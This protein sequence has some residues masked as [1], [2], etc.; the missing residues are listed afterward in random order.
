MI[1]KQLVKNFLSLFLSNV[2]GQLFSLWAFVKIASVFGPEGFGRFS[3]AQ[4]VALYFLFLADFGLQTLGTRTIAQEKGDISVHVWNITI[5]RFFLAMCCF[6]LLVIFSFL[7]PKPNEVRLLIII[8]GVALF[9]Y[10]LLLEWVFQGIEQMEYV[11]LGRVLKGVV[12]AGLVFFFINSPDNMVYAA[13]FYVVGFVFASGTLIGIYFRKHGMLISK[14]RYLNLK[15]ILISAIPLAAGSLIAQINYNFGTLALGFYQSDKV[16]GLFSAA[17]KI[18]L[19]L[20][21]FAAVAASNAILPQL[22]RSYKESIGQFNNSLKKLFRVFILFAIPLGIGGSILASR[23]MGFLYTPEYQEAV[24]VF[25]L[26]IWMVVFVISRIVFENALI[27]SRSQRSYLIGFIGAG[28]F[29]ILGN[30]ILVPVLGLV[31]PSVVGILSESALV[32]YFV[33]SCK[34]IRSSEFVILIFKP[35]LAGLLMGLFL[36]FLPLSL[37][38]SLFI[39]IIIYFISLIILHYFTIDELNAYIHLLRQ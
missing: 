19:F 31:A 5:L 39:G 34:Y 29:T 16:V 2:I 38:V 14:Y 15:H 10:A 28:M 33:F 12:F 32:L 13:V 4:V 26:S 23:I 20:W 22:A 11:G 9:P 37:F 1:S 21:A 18:I 8:S 17:Y 3:F 35:L 30:I 27:V 7:L 6:V 36:Y 24:I 25:Q